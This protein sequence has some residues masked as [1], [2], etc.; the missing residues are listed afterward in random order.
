MTQAEAEEMRRRGNPVMEDAG[1]GWRRVVASPRP[2]AGWWSW[3]PSA[4]WPMRDRSSSPAAEAASGVAG[5]QPPAG[6]PAP[7]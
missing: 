2:P 5:W 1:R 4:H 7:W 6:R 3:T